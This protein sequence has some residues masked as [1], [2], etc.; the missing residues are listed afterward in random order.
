MTDTQGQSYISTIVLP[1]SETVH[2]IKDS[3]ARTA[4]TNVENNKHDK[5][6]TNGI[7]KGNGS[8]TITAA[9]AGTDYLAPVTAVTSP[10]ASGNTTSFIDTVSQGTNGR[11]SATKKTI[12]TASSSTAGIMKL[13]ASG[14]A[15]VYGAA[16]TA[17]TNAKAY[18]DSLI[19]GLGS[20]MTLKGTQTSE[21]AIKNLTSANKG[22]VYINTAD[23]SEWVCT[24]TITAKK[25]SAW[26][27]LGYNMDLSAYELKTNLGDLAYQDTAT[28]NFTPQGSIAINSYTPAGSVSVGTGTANYTPGGT[29]GTP[30]I[31]VTPNTTTVNS[32]TAVGTLP[33]W[34]AS[35][36]NE[37][38]SFSFSQGTLPTKGS[39]TTVVTSIKSATSTQPSW[40]GTGVQLKFTGTAATLTGSFTGTQGTVTVS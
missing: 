37:T 11:I 9:T 21:S 12:P 14:G 3:E 39:N 23:N 27:K 40:T 19:T 38:L 35:V 10:S 8:G 4:I 16:A 26:E 32:I 6:M 17:E 2:Y 18:A 25:E 24:E 7:L 1:G 29:V 33:S 36:E 13:G 31:T 34:S 5:I 22:D 30:T 28:G 20:Y 15:D